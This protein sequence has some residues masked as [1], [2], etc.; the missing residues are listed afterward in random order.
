MSKSPTRQKRPE[1]QLREHW[2]RLP[3][4][5]QGVRPNETAEEHWLR[6]MCYMHRDRMRKVFFKWALR[7][8]PMAKK[9]WR[10][11]GFMCPH[12]WPLADVGR[13]LMFGPER[14]GARRRERL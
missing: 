4:K 12:E 8:R 7:A 6:V 9:V 11:W 3:V 13:V 10:K 2:E 5:P 1:K 14:A